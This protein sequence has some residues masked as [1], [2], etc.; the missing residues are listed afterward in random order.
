[1]IDL[2]YGINISTD[3]YCILSQSTRLTDG[4]TDRWTDTFVV[5]IPRLHSMHRGKKTRFLDF[6]Y[7]KNFP[8]SPNFSFLK[9]FFRKALKI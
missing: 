8:R 6:F 7:K 5:A 2:S 9:V 1:M 3:L 4:Q